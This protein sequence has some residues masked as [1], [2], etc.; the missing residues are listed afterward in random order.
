M[1]YR[2][3]DWGLIKVGING[4]GVIGRRVAYAISKQDDM[5]LIGIGKTSPDYKAKIG[6]EKGFNFYVPEDSHKQKFEKSGFSVSGSIDDLITN[7]DIILDATP[8]SFGEMYREKYPLN[9]AYFIS[10]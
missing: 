7:S 2:T 9:N 5:E 10:F 1:I 6:I 3:G 4:F 8:G